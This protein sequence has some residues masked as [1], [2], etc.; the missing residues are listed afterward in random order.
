MNKQK[1]IILGIS[2]YM[3]SGKTTVGKYLKKRGCAFIDAD[4]VVDELYAVGNVGYEKIQSFFGRD[5]LKKSGEIDRQKLARFV[6][7]DKNKLKILNNLIHPLVFHEIKRIMTFM[8]NEVVAIEAT[9]FN[10]K[11]IGGLIDKMIWIECSGEVL[12]SRA[13]KK[14]KWH[15]DSFKKVI[16]VQEQPVK[17]DFVL[18]NNGTKGHLY[19]QIDRIWN[20]LR[21]W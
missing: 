12:H 16:K 9:Y 6:F 8:K 5:F 14:G 15:R 18:K 3:G 13:G 1:K 17:V 20:S 2:G 21:S 19:K 10:K 4:E 11:S 7:D